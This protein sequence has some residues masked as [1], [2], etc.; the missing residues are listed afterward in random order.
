MT[1]RG[2]DCILVLMPTI[3]PCLTF[4]HQAE[5]A[6]RF[7]VSA[8]RDAE[9]I[10]IT[11]CGPGEPRPAGTVRTVR[12]TLFGQEMM[13][14]NGGPSFTFTPAVSL[15]VHCETPAEVDSVW[16]PLTEGGTALMPLDEYPWASRF[17][18]IQDRFGVSWQVVA[19]AG[20]Q[21]IVPGLLFAAMFLT[22]W[23]FAN[24]FEEL[25]MDDEAA[26]AVVGFIW[27]GFN[28]SFVVLGGLTAWQLWRN[29]PGQDERTGA[30][31]TRPG[32]RNVP[33]SLSGDANAIP[34][35]G[36]REAAQ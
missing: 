8:F 15:F 20:R 18:W 16:E 34:G 13:A 10:N 5:E 19:A 28:A 36:G 17:G 31:L 24:W 25:S 29:G 6:I 27:I 26:R 32:S 1:W 7:Y 4:D 12:F 3:K 30:H 22:L 35:G 2:A 11:H 23:F 33:G 9:L 21:R 14:L